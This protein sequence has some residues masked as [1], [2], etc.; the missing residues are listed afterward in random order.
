MTMNKITCNEPP[1]KQTGSA[2]GA[3]MK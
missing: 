3:V 1:N 2:V